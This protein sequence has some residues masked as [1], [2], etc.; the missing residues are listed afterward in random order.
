MSDKSA[1][2]RQGEVASALATFDLDEFIICMRKA[3]KSVSPA[4][5][6]RAEM[7]RYFENPEAIRLAMPKFDMD[8]E[9]LFE[10]ETLTIFYCRFRPNYTIPP[11]DH[12]TSAVIGIYEGQERNSFF[13]TAGDAFITKGKSVDMQAGDVVSMGPHAIHTVECTG[14]TPS[15][16]IH[17]YLGPLTRIERNLYD[18]AAE[19]VIPFTDADFHRLVSDDDA[20]EPSQA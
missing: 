17:V 4:K 7:D 19:K 5:A 2:E 9:V 14:S 3:A 10:D 8:E 18:V 1:T 15:Y 11:H 16:A 20:V 13:S 6:V 12:Q